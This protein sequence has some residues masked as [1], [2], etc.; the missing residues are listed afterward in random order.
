MGLR[1]EVPANNTSLGEGEVGDGGGVGVGDEGR[2]M[3]R[4]GRARDGG[5]S[6]SGSLSH[7]GGRNSRRPRRSAVTNRS[8]NLPDRQAVK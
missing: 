5:S 3:G 7:K 1:E 6:P 4:D 2:G 8:A